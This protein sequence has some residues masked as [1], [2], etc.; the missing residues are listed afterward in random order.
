[1]QNQYGGEMNQRRAND[2]GRVPSGTLSRRR[3][4]ERASMGFGAAL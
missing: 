2:I 4:L 1:M 3:A